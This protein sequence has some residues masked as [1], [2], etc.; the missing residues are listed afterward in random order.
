MTAEHTF[1]FGQ[2]FDGVS[3]SSCTCGW[4][5]GR[6]HGSYEEAEDTWENHCDVVFMEA[7]EARREQ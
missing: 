6:E 3:F 7:T 4:E 1:I 5:S 2:T